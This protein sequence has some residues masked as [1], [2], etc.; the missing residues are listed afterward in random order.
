MPEE[1]KQRLKEY[2]KI[3][4]KQKIIIKIFYIFFFTWS[5]NG[6]KIVDF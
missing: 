5:K 1:N 3:I 6:I 4:A 2:Q